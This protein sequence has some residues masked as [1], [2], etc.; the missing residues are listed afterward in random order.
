M[1]YCFVMQPFDGDKYDKR[2][3]VIIKPTVE[4]LGYL[5]YRIDRDPTADILIESIEHKIKSSDFCI[6][7]ISTNNPNVWYELGFACAS[8]KKLIMVCS[9]ERGD[10]PFPFDIRHRNILIYKTKVPSDFE[11]YRESL[12]ARIQGFSMYAD[13]KALSSLE[14]ELLKRMYYKLNT[15][16]EVMPADQI[17]TVE[18][19][20]VLIALKK[21]ITNGY[22]Q[23]F[24]SINQSAQQS[25][26]YR[27]TEKGLSIINL[28]V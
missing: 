22:V 1:K 18:S 16:N 28:I 6:A 25:S 21:L 27:V 15:A 24:Y 10:E 2:F 20:D 11:R 19:E 8:G 13:E 5:A 17:P 23:Y 26:Y 14:I 4:S 3:D 7:E 12:R 9:E